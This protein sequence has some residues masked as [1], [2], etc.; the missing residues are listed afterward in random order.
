VV[1]HITSVIDIFVENLTFCHHVIKNRAYNCNLILECF[2]RT[3]YFLLSKWLYMNLDHTTKWVSFRFSKYKKLMV[4]SVWIS[5]FQNILF[6][7]WYYQKM[8]N[9]LNF[10]KKFEFYF[11]TTFLCMHIPYSHFCE[12]TSPDYE[13]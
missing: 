3:S 2:W 10:F 7:I 12:Y 11:V 8:R 9:K 4:F 6:Q 5:L 1:V 13:T